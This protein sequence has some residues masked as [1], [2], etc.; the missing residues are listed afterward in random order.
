MPGI[1]LGRAS[2]CQNALSPA[3]SGGG[4]AFY[5]AKLTYSF[6]DLSN[7]G[8]NQ[9]SYQNISS[10]EIERHCGSFFNILSQNHIH[11]SILPRVQICSDLSL[12]E[13]FIFALKKHYFT[14]SIAIFSPIFPLSWKWI[15]LR[16]SRITS[17]KGCFSL[18]DRIWI[19]LSWRQKRAIS[20]PFFNH[21]S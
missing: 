3:H 11:D 21:K 14:S 8:G 16:G 5:P 15:R 4:G 20:V 12:N 9:I 2:A 13:G 10:N 18:S 19:R 7:R 6:N 1:S 17:M